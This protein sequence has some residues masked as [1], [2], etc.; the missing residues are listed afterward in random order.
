MRIAGFI[1]WVIT[2]V[3]FVTAPVLLYQLIVIE[4]FPERAPPL[5]GAP[6]LIAEMVRKGKE[7]Y[8]DPG[9]EPIVSQF[10]WWLGL[11]IIM[12][13]PFVT[14]LAAVHLF[15]MTPLLFAVVSVPG[16][17]ARRLRKRRRRPPPGHTG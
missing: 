6:P 8:G 13:L 16:E 17:I 1:A 5:E 4:F 14:E 2:F 15:W 11:L 9:L 7:E 3:F 12:L 10:A